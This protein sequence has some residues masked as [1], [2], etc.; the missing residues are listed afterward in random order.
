MEIGIEIG[1][2][3]GMEIGIEIVHG[4]GR[5]I[6]HQ[7]LHFTLL[8]VF[9]FF[10]FFPF[11]PS[12]PNSSFLSY[13]YIYLLSFINIYVYMLFIYSLPCIISSDFFFSM[14]FSFFLNRTYLNFQTSCNFLSIPI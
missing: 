10:F 2:D 7:S 4:E 8:I 1:M 3:M 11:Y 14:Y 12:L 6:D 5:S 13:I 9:F